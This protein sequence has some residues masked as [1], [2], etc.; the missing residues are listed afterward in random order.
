MVRFD[1]IHTFYAYK[2]GEGRPVGLYVIKMKN[3]VAQLERL[4]Y[5][6]V[7]D[8]SVA[9]ILNGPSSGRIQ[10]SIKK[11]LDAKGKGK[12][13]GK[14][15]DKSYI[16]KPKN[17]KPSAKEHT[18]KDDTAK[19]W[20]NAV[21]EAH[22]KVACLMLESMTPELHG[23]LENSSPYEIL[24]ELKSMF[25]KQARME[26]FDLIHS[27]YA[28]KQE[29]GRP[30]G[31]YVIKMKNYVAQLERL[32]GKIQ[33]SIKK[34]LNAK[35]KGKGKGKGK[36]KSYI[37]KPKN[38]KPF[39]EEHPAKDDTCHHYK[40]VGHWKK[41]FHGYLVVLIKKKKKVSTASSPS[42]FTIELFFFLINHGCTTLVVVL[43]SV[44]QNR[45]LEEKEN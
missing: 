16:P 8:L 27:F 23:Q 41:N 20:W 17:P 31:P 43:T 38:P 11:S 28:Y 29:E 1:L 24:Q 22:N 33:K 26:R 30:V 18:T 19:K 7:Q 6:L 21:Y 10:K 9:L 5:V 4:G 25:E 15:K 34:S 37:P 13:K 2:Q 12:G 36:D 40:E 44:T 39:A 32:G 45:V 42:I 3:Y 35:G 14:G